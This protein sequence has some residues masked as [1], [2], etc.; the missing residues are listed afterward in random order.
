MQ[1]C[2]SL[3]LTGV[4]MEFVRV[5][6]GMFLMGGDKRK[7]LEARRQELPQHEVYLEEYWMGKYPV[8]NTQYMEFVKTTGR[9]QPHHWEKAAR[10]TV[11]NIFFHGETRSLIRSVATS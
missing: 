10:G 1:H 8:T 7:D 11:G 6:E 4:K 3:S 9:N 5:P 2:N